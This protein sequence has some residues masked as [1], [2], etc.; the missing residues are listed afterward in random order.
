VARKLVAAENKCFALLLEVLESL[1]ARKCVK[2]KDILRGVWL[3]Q[4]VGPHLPTSAV[5][6]PNQ[7]QE[8]TP[9]ECGVLHAISCDSKLVTDSLQQRNH[10]LEVCSEVSPV[11]AWNGDERTLTGLPFHTSYVEYTSL[12][13]RQE[14]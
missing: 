8:P 13:I 9:G 4:A 5:S 2:R 3:Q 10:M 11:A 12:R 14:Y 6:N 7:H 1:G